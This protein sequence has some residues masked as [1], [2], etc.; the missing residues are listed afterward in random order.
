MD[1][2]E[3]SLRVNIQKW[4]TDRNLQPYADKTLKKYL[5]DIRKLAPSN[6]TDM[7]WAEDTKKIASQL[8]GYKPTT[9]RNYYNSLLI[10]LYAS[11]VNKGTGVAR[12]YEAKR[13]MLNAQYDNLGGKTEKQQEILKEVGEEDIDRML[14][15]MERDLRTRQTFMVY[16]MIH[17]Y[18]RFAFRN[19]VAGMEVFP[20][21]IF[22]KIEETERHSHNYLVLGKPPESMSFVLNDYK[23]SKKYG[24]KTFEIEDRKLQQI[25]HSWISYKISNRWED[26][27]NKVIFLFD[28]ATGTPLTRND[29]SHALSDAFNKYLGHPVSTTLLRKIYSKSLIDPNIASDQEVEEVIHQADISGHS[30]KV[31]AKIYHS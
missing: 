11:G 8:K 14:K 20:N 23:T 16:V 15:A 25:L 2:Y 31:K 27:E 22:D 4:K 29:I 1:S 30:V 7:D 21:A 17:I 3:A 18:R 26:I 19:D 24:E 28:W 9:Q 5:S 12:I 6:F 10:G 13:D